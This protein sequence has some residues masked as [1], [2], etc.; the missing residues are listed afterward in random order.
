[1]SV[2]VD[3]LSKQL[4]GSIDGSIVEHDDCALLKKWERAPGIA[5]VLSSF[6]SKLQTNR[7][8]AG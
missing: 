8:Y 4:P 2:R 5:Y 7:F 1:M 3:L 6:L